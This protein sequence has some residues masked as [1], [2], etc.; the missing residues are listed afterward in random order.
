MNN[1]E[2]RSS[3]HSNTAICFT[4]AI[5]YSGFHHFFSLYIAVNIASLISPHSELFHYYTKKN[6]SSKL[7]I[8]IHALR[9]GII[10][11]APVNKVIILQ[12]TVFFL[13]CNENYQHVH[14]CNFTQF[15]MV[16]LCC[17]LLCFPLCF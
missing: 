2:Y 1:V 9:A 11:G 16:F 13:M 4:T 6:L 3:K 15:S 12:S 8:N 5:P 10:F 7:T 17:W 14:I